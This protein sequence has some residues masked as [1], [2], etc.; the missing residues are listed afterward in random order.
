MYTNTPILFV[1]AL[2]ERMRLPPAGLPSCILHPECRVALLLSPLLFCV[3]SRRSKHQTGGG[4]DVRGALCPQLHGPA[5]LKEPRNKGRPGS[6]REKRDAQHSNTA[7]STKLPL[8]N[9]LALALQKDSNRNLR[10][11]VS[12]RSSP[13]SRSA[14]SRSPAN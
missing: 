2:T 11:F 6:R 13:A 7:P 10:C 8:Q 5:H 1:P 4:S 14:V 12:N 3:V 9:S